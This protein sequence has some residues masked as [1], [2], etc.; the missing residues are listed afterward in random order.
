MDGFVIE[1]L[2]GLVLLVRLRKLLTELKR[3]FISLS[4]DGVV[5]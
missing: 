3:M 1:L 5:S 2:F 4:V